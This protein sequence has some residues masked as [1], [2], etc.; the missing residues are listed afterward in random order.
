MKDHSAIRAYVFGREEDICRCCRI[1]RAESMHE[2]VSRGRRGKVSKRNS[3]AVCGTLVG[4]EPCCHTYLQLNQIDWKGTPEGAEGLLQFR[5][6]TPKAAEWM[7]VARY[8]W[9]C[10]MPGSRNAELESC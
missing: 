3:I 7:R 8:L 2:L 6:T 9:V 4:T 5:P 10:S 1:R